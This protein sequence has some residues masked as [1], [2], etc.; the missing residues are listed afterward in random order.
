M[1]RAK[2]ERDGTV[3]IQTLQWEFQRCQSLS[4]CFDSLFCFQPLQRL[5]TIVEFVLWFGFL[6]HAHNLVSGL[7]QLA[8]GGDWGVRLGC[9]CA[10][11]IN[12]YMY[13]ICLHH[14]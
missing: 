11:T 8:T 4:L 12:P 2:K 10:A 1:R 13:I 9:I 5:P 3:G 7:V 14:N 6:I